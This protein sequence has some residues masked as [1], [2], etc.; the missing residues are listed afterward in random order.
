[1]IMTLNKVEMHCEPDHLSLEPPP[2]VLIS[3]GAQNQ[4]S[5]ILSNERVDQQTPLIWAPKFNI[6]AT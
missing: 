4:R 6:S 2:E 5:D 1:M 3:I